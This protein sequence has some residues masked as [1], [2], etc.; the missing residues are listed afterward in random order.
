M[1][2]TS[3]RE[4][5]LLA[6]GSGGG[7]SGAEVIKGTFTIPDSGSSYTLEIGKMLEKYAY[8]I[9]LTDASKAALMDTDIDNT[10]TFLTYGIYPSP[11]MGSDTLNNINANVRV[12]PHTGAVTGSFNSTPVTGISGSQFALSCGAVA[13]GAYVMFHGYS[14]NYTIIDLS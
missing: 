14:Y 7:G 8:I 4:L 9:E 10:R 13:S 3:L 2:R 1:D 12:N 5:M 11:S 6:A